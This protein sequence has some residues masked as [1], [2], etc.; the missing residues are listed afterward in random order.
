MYKNFELAFKSTSLNVLLLVK[1][2][3][4]S[5]QPQESIPFEQVL[6]MLDKLMAES[7][8]VE[9]VEVFLKKWGFE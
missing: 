7:N 4:N 5:M 9:E 2:V 6:E 3:F 8:S 1:G